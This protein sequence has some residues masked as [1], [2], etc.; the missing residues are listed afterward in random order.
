MRRA[1][2]AIIA[3][4]FLASSAS[5]Q[6]APRLKIQVVDVGAGLC[7]VVTAPGP[8]YM[9]YDAGN[10]EDRG[11]TAM[12]AIEAAIPY[13]SNIDLMV[14]SHG[15]ADHLAAVPYIC[16]NYSVRQVWRDGL[17]RPTEN[18]RNADRAIRREVADESCLDINLQ[19][20]DVDPGY[21]IAL[22]DATVTFIA[23]FGEIPQDWGPLSQGENVN[24]RSV[25][26]RVD[27][28][29]SSILL[30]GDTVGRHIGDA[31]HVCIAAEKVMVDR[32]AEVSVDVDVVVAAHHGADNA[33]SQA[34]VR[35]TSPRYVVFSAGSKHGHPSRNAARRYLNFGVSR[36]N[37]FRTDRGDNEGSPYEW[38]PV[39]GAS[40]DP[41]GDD[42][43]LISMARNGQVSIAHQ[44]RTRF[45]STPRPL[46]TA[47]N[48]AL[49]ADTASAFALT[50][51]A[52][53]PSAAQVAP[54]SPQVAEF[55]LNDAL[56]GERHEHLEEHTL[57][58]DLQ[59]RDLAPVATSCRPVCGSRASVR[60]RCRR[61]FA[62]RRCL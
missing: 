57:E 44:S 29:E 2:A 6:G 12:T 4:L 18:W 32:A 14:I 35:A 40:H 8:R 28:G 56:W 51:S 33:S 34:F 20:Y 3:A 11:V 25:V 16:R 31:N 17:A 62:F 24:A 22:G 7:C 43:V 36:S 60:C 13:G 59:P 38:E 49:A 46:F 30:T 53:A 50:P 41:A 42:D 55:V 54:L 39:S 47:P 19:N 52:D 15:D 48:A 1:F 21:Q 10:Y 61:W 26:A 27:Y 37:I 45:W 5:G 23:G 58:K 9:I